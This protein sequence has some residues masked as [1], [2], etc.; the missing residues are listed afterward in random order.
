MCQAIP[1]RVLQVCEG[2]AEV[3]AGDRCEWVSTVALPDIAPGEYVLVYAGVAVERVSEAEALELL[4]FL[5]SLDDLFDEEQAA[6]L[7]QEQVG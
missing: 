2:R 3:V 6:P 1:R 4:D 5:A 7:S